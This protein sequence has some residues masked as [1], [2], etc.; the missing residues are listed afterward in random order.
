M[1]LKQREREEADEFNKLLIA[2]YGIETRQ[3]QDSSSNQRHLLIAPYGI[4]TK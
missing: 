4:E 1:G 2:P 3:P